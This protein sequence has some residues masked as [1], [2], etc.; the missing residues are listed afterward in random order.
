[1]ELEFDKIQNTNIKSLNKLITPKKLI[2]ELSSLDVISKIFFNR[3]I[4]SNIIS[5]KDPRLLFIV[6]P[7]SIHNIEEAKEYGAKLAK[8]T[9]KVE[10]K[11][12]IVMRVYF[13]KP[14]ST[15]GWKGFINDPNLNNTCDINN[16]IYKARELL[17]YLNSINIPCAYEILDT[18]T[19]QYIGDLISWG[20]IGARTTESQVHRQLVSGLSMPVGFK[21]STSGN[22]DICMDAIVSSKYPHSFMGITDEGMAAIFHTNGNNNCHII[23]RGGKTPNYNKENIEQVEDLLKKRDIKTRILVDCSHGNSQKDHTKQENILNDVILQIKKGNKS[24]MGVMIESN[25]NEGN[26]KLDFNNPQLLEKGVS[27]TDSCIDF[28]TTERI[29]LKSYERISNSK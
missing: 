29:I 1:M 16:G 17:I 23:L 18:L 13:E 24:I 26:Q 9:K 6:G 21:N 28:E 11:I 8:L 15:T 7:C 3:E 2:E 10:D 14:R 5:Y 20:A 22:V 19:P 4:I 25:I 12:H 27:I